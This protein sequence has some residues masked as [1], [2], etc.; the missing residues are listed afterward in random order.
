[1]PESIDLRDAAITGLVVVVRLGEVTLLDAHHLDAT[2][3]CHERWGI[4]GFSV[5]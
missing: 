1:M 3:R 4:W 5:L 2:A